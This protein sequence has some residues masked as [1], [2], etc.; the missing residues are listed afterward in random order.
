MVRRKKSR[1]KSAAFRFYDKLR[2]GGGGRRDPKIRN[3]GAITVIAF[4]LVAGIAGIGV[5][6]WLIFA[7]AVYALPFFIALSV[8]FAAYHAG[9]GAGALLVGPMA[10][11][12]ALVAGQTLFAPMR[13]PALRGVI[14]LVF[15][16]PAA[17]AGY[18][19]ILAVSQLGDLSPAWR[20]A[21]ALAGSASVAC[22]AWSRI[23]AR[24]PRLGRADRGVE[25]ILF[26]P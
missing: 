11:A 10:G 19:T 2:R 9:A 14:A 1:R 23:A 24:S 25:T 26:G 12:I 20:Q 13:P 18:E 3:N 21:F 15:A 6:C 16:V 5:F 7:L 22:A 8:G 4:G 17:I